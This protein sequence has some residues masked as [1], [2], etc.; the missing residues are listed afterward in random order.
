MQDAE[1]MRNA[2]F[3]LKR[4]QIEDTGVNSVVTACGGCR[5]YLMAGGMR[6]NWDT[7]VES[8]VELVGENLK[9]R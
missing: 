4:Q 3:D 8:L 1:P 2:A 7:K 9:P 5:I 6:T